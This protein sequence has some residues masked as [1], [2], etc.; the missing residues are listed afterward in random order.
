MAS[1][2]SRPTKPNLVVTVNVFSAP[3]NSKPITLPPTLGQT[4]S[5]IGQVKNVGSATTSASKVEFIITGPLGTVDKKSVQPG[6]ALKPGKTFNRS[7]SFTIAKPGHYA[8]KV[9]ADPGSQVNESNENDNTAALSFDVACAGGATMCGTCVDTSTDPKNC[10]GCGKQ[11]GPTETCNGSCTLPPGPGLQASAIQ[12]YSGDGFW[13]ASVKLAN[14]TPAPLVVKGPIVVTSKVVGFD[15]NPANN[16]NGKPLFTPCGAPETSVQT[17]TLNQ[18]LTMGQ[19]AS[20]WVKVWP[21]LWPPPAECHWKGGNSAPPPPTT[22]LQVEASYSSVVGGVTT[23]YQ[24]TFACD[25]VVNFTAPVIH[26][27]TPCTL[28]KQTTLP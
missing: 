13:G 18:D 6:I 20:A 8:V 3:P 10:G 23:K 24:R 1:A 11:C 25:A 7:E 12:E 19:H 5:F 21:Y 16:V 9:S 22:H 2:A 17:K 26:P 4:V 27:E 14:S 15:W 28:V